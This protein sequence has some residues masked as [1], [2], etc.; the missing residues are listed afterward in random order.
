MYRLFSIT[1]VASIVLHATFS[2]T[3]HASAS[4]TS[5]NPSGNEGCSCQ[6]YV[7]TAYDVGEPCFYFNVCDNPG[8][9][10]AD[11]SIGEESSYETQ[12]GV[13]ATICS[14]TGPLVGGGCT[15]SSTESFC[16][17]LRICTCDPFLECIP[18]LQEGGFFF[19]CNE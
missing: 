14:T 12:E 19:P 1:A 18:G 3:M 2:L 6:P 4:G 17:M 11:I 8:E 16:K 7:C 9:S 10:C 5:C 15:S 13:G